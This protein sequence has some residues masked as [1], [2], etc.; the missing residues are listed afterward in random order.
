M[1]SMIVVRQAASAELA[2]AGPRAGAD[3]GDPRMSV[4]AA[5]A[6]VGNMGV[7][8][9]T[10]GGW[11]IT[12]R[13]DTETCFILSGAATMTDDATGEKHEITAGDLIVLPAGWSGRW[14]IT[15]TL[16]KVYVVH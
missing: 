9:C 11:Q 1:T 14:D 6:S 15:E 16:R 12:N 7:W 10:P 3:S 5:P 4:L 8:E 13:G 2:P